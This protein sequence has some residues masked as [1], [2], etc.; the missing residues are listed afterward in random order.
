LQAV[1]RSGS[2]N[3]GRRYHPIE[4]PEDAVHHHPFLKSRLTQGAVSGYQYGSFIGRQN[5]RGQ[6]GFR[7][8]AVSRSQCDRAFDLR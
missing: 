1:G 5:E 7:R 6:V 8:T 3:D 4:E 2:V